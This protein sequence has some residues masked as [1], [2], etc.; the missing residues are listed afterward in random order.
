MISVVYAVYN[1]EAILA[2]SLESVVAWADEIVIVDGESTDK[3]V[4]IAKK[5]GA[6]VIETTNK[7]N[8]HIN[9]QMAI[10]AARGDLILQL[11]ADEVVDGQ[12]RDFVQKVDREKPNAYAAWN[13]RRKNLFLRHWMRKGG[14]YPDM[15]IRLFYAGK[16]FLPQKDVH[17]Q[18]TV[19]GKVGVAAGHLLHF[20][21]PDLASYFRKFNTYTSFKALQLAEAKVKIGPG[22]FVKYCFWKPLATFV[23]LFGRHRGYVDGLAGFLFATFSGW[24][25]LV[26]YCKYVENQRPQP[27]G[28]V[29][30]YYPE[31]EQERQAARGVGRY[32]L[33]LL[34]SV[35]ADGQVQIC[36]KAA[37][38]NVIHYTFF[39]LYKQTLQSVKKGQ[40]LVVTVHDLI[41]LLFPKDFPVGMRGKWNLWWQKRRLRKADAIVTDSAT[42]KND[43]VKLWRIPEEKIQVVYLAANP[44]L[45]PASPQEIASVKKSY[46]LP[47]KYL[48]YVGDINFN[49]N[50][51]QLIK[52]LKFLPEDINLVMVGKNFIPSEI[53]EWITIQ[54]QL[55]LSEVK[56]RVKFLSTITRDAE[57]SALYSGALAYVQPSMY[58]G[59]GLP[60]L[61]AMR[62]KTVVICHKNSSL[63]EIG[64]AHVMYAESL[65]AE[66]FAVAVEKVMAM[67]DGKREKFLQAA[68]LWQQGF[69]WQR[70][71]E[72]MI[73]I[74]EKVAGE[75]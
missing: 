35:E 19:K 53:P 44:A 58:E 8:F 24:H 47:E 67:P 27:D 4:K 65:R 14:Q 36:H 26:A 62:C 37:N 45:A 46:V 7:P 28:R 13:V 42:T 73:Q 12:L 49:K 20:A 16:A 52:A 25:H 50:L 29:S 48:L 70:V 32:A 6:R 75:T 17:E 55:D 51:A 34:E 71:S 57:L 22:N 54:E 68:Y 39:D 41:P 33:W 40:K 1:E 10:E 43:L 69:T 3:T 15:V 72:Q 64:S 63:A 2:R 74:Y 21:N 23:S 31:N 61:E 11:D 56:S 5:F 30:V 66:D 60:V 59:F 38:T 18:M 9:K